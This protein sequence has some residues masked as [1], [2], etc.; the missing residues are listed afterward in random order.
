M[1]SP[2]EVEVNGLEARDDIGLGSLPV[3]AQE[4]VGFGVGGGS[5]VVLNDGT[6]GS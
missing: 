1:S 3:T 2:S 6:K 5:G 4:E